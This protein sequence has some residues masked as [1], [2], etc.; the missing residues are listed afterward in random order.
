MECELELNFF[1]F[2]QLSFISGACTRAIYDQLI[3]HMH[4]YMCNTGSYAISYSACAGEH[5]SAILIICH[6]QCIPE[7]YVQARM[8][9]LFKMGI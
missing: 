3:E 7:R 5:Q 8:I 2:I 9:E 4:L 1:K 6:D